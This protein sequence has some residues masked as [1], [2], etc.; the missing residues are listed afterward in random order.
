MQELNSDVTQE[1]INNKEEIISLKC[2]LHEN[3]QQ[4]MNKF[5][6]DHPRWDQYRILQA[7][8]AGFLM[9]KGFQNRDLTRQ[10]IGNMFP[11]DFD[12]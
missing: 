12:K 3:L 9:Q 6:E 10:Y 7:A 11:M 1:Y 4:A 5:V 2:D 8:I